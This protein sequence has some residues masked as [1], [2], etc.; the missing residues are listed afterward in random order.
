LNVVEAISGEA[1]VRDVRMTHWSGD[2]TK[3]VVT[4]FVIVLHRE[5]E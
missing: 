3:D 5:T 2:R 1:S 4:I